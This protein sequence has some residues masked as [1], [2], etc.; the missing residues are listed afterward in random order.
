MKLVSFINN[1]DF[2]AKWGILQN[3]EILVLSISQKYP[4]LDSFIASGE[5]IDKSVIEK[6]SVNDVRLTSPVSAKRNIFCVG[7]NYLDHLNEI[8]A[9]A[10]N[11]VPKFPSF[12]TKSS[13]T[14]NGPYDNVPLHGNA[15]SGVDYEGEIA[16]IIGKECRNVS[17]EDAEDYIFGYA[18]ANDVTAR[19]LQTQ[20]MQWFKGKSLDGFCP[21]GPA[22]VTKD[23]FNTENAE[24]T[25][26]VNGEMRQHSFM[27]NMIFDVPTIIYYLSQGM[28][29]LPGDIILTGTPSGVGGG[30]NPPL[31]LKDGDVV[32]I[33]VSGIGHIENK[34]MNME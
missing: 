32:K 7:K 25:T 6:I 17:V 18:I 11:S 2:T 24:I 15:T 21:I 30:K 13:M 26:Y 19:D 1:N 10:A 33:E 34:F 27:S 14:L 16:V 12:F 9:T 20:H 4:T 8:K 3:E 5:E 28:T 23:E 31:Y 22:V 29:L